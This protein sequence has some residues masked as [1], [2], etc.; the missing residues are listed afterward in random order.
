MDK[1]DT[2]ELS[3]GRLI[4]IECNW[5]ALASYS[6]KVGIE[7]LAE[8]DNIA[9]IKPKKL[10]ILIYECAAE[11]EEMQGRN[12]ELS[13]KEFK[14]LLRFNSVTQF[15]EIFIKQVVPNLPNENEKKQK[16]RIGND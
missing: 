9:L 16:K 6:E 4:A 3:N 5:A 12:L 7:T 1:K 8:M 13:F 2:I 15:N 10:P 11:G 14:K